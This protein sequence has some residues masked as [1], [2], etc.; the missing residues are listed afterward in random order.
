MQQ[1]TTA[2]R[3]KKYKNK[4]GTANNPGRSADELAKGR[5]SSSSSSSS[6]DKD[7]ALFGVVVVVVVVVVAVVVVISVDD[8]VAVISHSHRILLAVQWE[9]CISLA[10]TLSLSYM[11]LQPSQHKNDSIFDSIRFDSIRTRN[12][13]MNAM[14]R[15][16]QIMLNREEYRSKRIQYDCNNMPIQYIILNFIARWFYGRWAR[17]KLMIWILLSVGSVS[18][19]E[20]HWRAI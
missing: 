1:T 4:T 17:D 6:I 11:W 14:R 5:T 12:N 7:K 19:T 20:Q 8:V 13:R 3:N 2:I 16:N 10:H 18:H 15:S 9:R